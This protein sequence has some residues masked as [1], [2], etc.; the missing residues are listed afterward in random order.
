MAD[1][2]PGIA[3]ASGRTTAGGLASFDWQVGARMQRQRMRLGMSRA[4]LASQL[5]Q[6]EED[7]ESYERGWCRV[8][9]TGLRAIATLLD[10]D[11]TFFY[12]QRPAHSD[13]LAPGAGSSRCGAE[14]SLL[15]SRVGLCPDPSPAIEQAA[16]FV[17]ALETVRAFC[18]QAD[19]GVREKVVAAIMEIP[20][21]EAARRGM[22]AVRL[23]PPD[24][25][26]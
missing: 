24:W 12:G 18:R 26:L 25:T 3:V 22:E 8:D 20:P 21:G 11:M 7:I 9:A 1:D 15:T 19:S 17:A 23:A 2:H 13:A 14:P 5:G 16:A 10:V 4:Q 6:A